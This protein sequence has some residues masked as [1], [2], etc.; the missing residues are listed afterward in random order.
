[1]VVCLAACGST[2]GGKASVAQ[3]GT[4]KVGAP[5][6][7][8]GVWYTP[9][10]DFNHV[11]TGVASWYGP[12]FHGKSTANGERYDQTDRT[13]AH[14]TLQMPSIVRVTNLSNG[15]STVVRINDRGPFASNRV[16]DLSRTAAQELDVI[17]NGTARVRIE[18]LQAESLAVKDVAING[19]GPAEQHAV[20]A[21]LASGKRAPQQPPQV[22]ATAQPAAPPPTQRQVD[23]S[24]VNGGPTI[25][26]LATAPPAISASGFYVQT[27][28]F[29]TAEN[30][31]R[32]RGAVRSYGFSEISQASA[33]GRD[34]YR[35][36]LGPYTTA[37]AAG[38]VADR[39]KRS[40]YG[41]ARVVGD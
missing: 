24:S 36:R 15:L 17:R 39:L 10:E 25:A 28:S 4:Y 1:M 12:G 38:I 35:V 16:I 11:E 29:S 6:K 41:D 19:G 23:V 9:K 2:S 8:D 31:E 22:M 18:Q 7:I 33:S 26:S 5:Y 13:A 30:A 32:Q 40:G 3:R 34:V 37:D 20:I 14:R 21:Q 27:G